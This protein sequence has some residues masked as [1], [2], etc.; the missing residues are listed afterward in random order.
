MV[1]IL[2]FAIII[3]LIGGFIGL[4]LGMSLVLELAFIR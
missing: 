2:E 4:M 3:L 1:K